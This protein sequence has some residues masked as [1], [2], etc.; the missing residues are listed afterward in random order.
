MRRMQAR[1]VDLMFSSFKLLH[2][3][4]GSVTSSHSAVGVSH[5]NEIRPSIV[6]LGSFCVKSF[7]KAQALPGRF[8]LIPDLSQTRLEF[9]TGEER[10]FG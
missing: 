2:Q 7:F 4:K 9:H 1:P 10:R 3:D 6:L 5:G 8:Y